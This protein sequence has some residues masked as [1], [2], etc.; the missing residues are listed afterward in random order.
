MGDNRKVL[1]VHIDPCYNVVTYRDKNREV[2]NMQYYMPVQVYEEAEAVK[3]HAAVFRAAGKKAMIVTGRH[4]AKANGSY[5]DVCAVLKEAG[6]DHVLFDQVEENPSIE[7]VMKARDIAVS[8]HVDFG[9]GGGSPL[10]ASKAIAL[11]AFH[12]EENADYLYNNKDTCRLPL[13]VIPTTCG[14]GS[15]VT[16][17]SVLTIHAKKTKSSIPHKLFADVALID[18]KYLASAPAKVILNTAVDALGHLWESYCN[19]D[20]NDYSRMYVDAG[21]KVWRR[22]K[23]ALLAAAKDPELFKSFTAEQFGDLMRASEFAG[24]AIAQDGTSLPHAL[25][26]PVTYELHMAHGPAIGYFL[27]GYLAEAD[28]AD[29]NYMLNTAGFESLDE[30]KQYYAAVCTAEKL[31]EDLLQ[32]TM[33]TVAAMP[34]KLKKAPFPVDEAV[35]HRVVFGE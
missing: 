13:I 16:G 17:V 15:E 8:E 18:G 4:S 10:D 23:E 21:L 7:T 26:Y 12:K 20:A 11:M 3:N 6:I 1:F 32:L 34:A 28:E 25:S 9:I 22:N 14:T 24:M 29:R 5:D 33:D 31:P 19:A 27:A 35:L 2:R 30:W